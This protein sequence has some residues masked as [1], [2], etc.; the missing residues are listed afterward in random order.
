MSPTL[1]YSCATTTISSY[2][3]LKA[4]EAK[5]KADTDL[6]KK[7]IEVVEAKAQADIEKAKREVADR[8]LMF[9]YAA[10]YQRYQKKIGSFKDD[11][12][13]TGTDIL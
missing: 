9:G 5:A 4:A 2:Y 10:E 12:D 1:R 8:F 11:D 7:D 6:A 13:K 3:F